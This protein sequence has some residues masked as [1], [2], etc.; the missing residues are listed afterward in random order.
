[1]ELNKSMRNLGRRSV[2]NFYNLYAEVFDPYTF[3][4]KEYQRYESLSTVEEIDL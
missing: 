4:E 1:M 2:T 3:S